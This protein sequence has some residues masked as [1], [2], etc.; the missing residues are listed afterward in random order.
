MLLQPLSPQER[1]A[2]LGAN[3][4]KAHNLAMSQAP[5]LSYQW[6]KDFREAFKPGFKFV[7]D[8]PASDQWLDDIEEAFRPGFK[9]ME[10]HLRRATA[11][12]SRCLEM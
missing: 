10:D 6:L 12:D 9:F 8:N 1:V 7:K 5:Q 3:I 2:I 11:E 4:M